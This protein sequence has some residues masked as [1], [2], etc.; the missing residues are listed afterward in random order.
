MYRFI[1]LLTVEA[2]TNSTSY[3]PGCGGEC[4]YVAFQFGVL[5]AMERQKS[6]QTEDTTKCC[7]VL[8]FRS[9][10]PFPSLPQI[11]R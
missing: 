9:F 2:K 3:I 10:P 7:F 1:A 6:P 11:F 8:K 5:Q 4:T